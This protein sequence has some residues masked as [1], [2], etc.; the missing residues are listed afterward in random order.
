MG[1]LKNQEHFLDDKFCKKTEERIS[2]PSS[3]LLSNKWKFDGG[4][5]GR[6]MK[7]WTRQLKLI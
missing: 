1:N 7:Q 3:G 2:G 5:G 6:W 4:V